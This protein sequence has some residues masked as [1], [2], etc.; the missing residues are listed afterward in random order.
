MLQRQVSPD[1]VITYVSPLLRRLGVAHAFSTR[2]GGISP[3]PFDSLNLGNPS[4]CDVR[5]DSDRIRQNY[6]RFLRAAG[7]EG[8]ELMAVH[9]V[10]GAGVVRVTRGNP[11][12]NDTKADAL[13]SDDPGRVLSVRVADCVPLLLATGDGRAVA[14]VHAGWCGVVAGIAAGAIRMLRDGDAGNRLVAAIGPA[15]GFDAFEVGSD[16]LD[17]FARRFGADAPIRRTADGK[18]RVDLRACLRRQLNEAGISDD[19]IDGTDRCTHAHADEFFSH[20][21]DRGVSGRMAAVVAPRH[22]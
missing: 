13:V 2:I 5:D 15:I 3:A 16:V 12:D 22:D 20:R 19:R 21:R 8:R 1:G 10:H 4:G 17:E 6:R 18:G 11:H 7:C 14:A 9:Q